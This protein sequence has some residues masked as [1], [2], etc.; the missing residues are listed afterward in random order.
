MPFV[1]DKEDFLIYVGRINQSKGT[2]V[3]VR[4]A[5]KLN[6]KLVIIG[7]IADHAYFK[8]YV[9]PY[10]DGKILCTWARSTLR[11]RYSIFL[12]LRHSYTQ[13]SMRNS[14]A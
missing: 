14:S 10:I 13:Y 8:K 9:R 5:K 11:L 3:V 1:K 6:E 7:P 12:R 2:H 4:I